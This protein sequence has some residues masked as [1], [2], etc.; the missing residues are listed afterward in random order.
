MMGR[1]SRSLDKIMIGNKIVDNKSE[2]ADEFVSFFTTK[3]NN[4]LGDYIPSNVPKIPDAVLPFNLE[5][6]K[7]AFDRLSNK[8]SCGM[9]NIELL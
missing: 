3:V 1:G 7:N 4:L 9:D 2:I 8:K 6:I 5:E